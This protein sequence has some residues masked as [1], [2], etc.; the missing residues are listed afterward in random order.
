MENNRKIYYYDDTSDIPGYSGALIVENKTFPV[1]VRAFDG[2]S[3][4]RI[5]SSDGNLD[6]PTRT[7]DIGGEIHIVS[8]PTG[9][10]GTLSVE[11]DL[12]VGGAFGCNG[13]G[14]QPSYPVNVAATN[15]ATTQ[16]L[17]NQLRSALIANGI[18]I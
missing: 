18:C 12:L 16:T 4:I 14:V 5:G 2:E 15:A 8:N 10:G 11:S 9:N 3:Y 17:V 13:S 6:F 1:L 7:V